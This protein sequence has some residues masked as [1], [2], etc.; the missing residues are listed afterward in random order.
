MKYIIPR[1]AI[2]LGDLEPLDEM[3]IVGCA[4]R[5][6]PVWQPEHYDLALEY[7]AVMRVIANSRFSLGWQKEKAAGI[8]ADLARDPGHVYIM[9]SDDGAYYK[10]GKSIS[11]PRRLKEVS[12]KMPFG[13]TLLC[14]IK[15]DDM[16]KLEK[17]LH[18]RFKAKRCKGEWFK[19]TQGDLDAIKR[20]YKPVFTKRP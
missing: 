20:E 17:T 19:L 4:D 5:I 10:I 2:R 9:V 6:D 16:C 13:V 12:P 8:L 3:Y 18:R 14:A 11:P 15:T 1:R 7:K